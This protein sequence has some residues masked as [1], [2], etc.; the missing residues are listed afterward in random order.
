MQDS[1]NYWLS[2]EKRF[3]NL[4]DPL[5]QHFGI[6][7]FS[8]TK[9]YLDG[10]IFHLCNHVPWMSYYFNHGLYNNEEYANIF[11]LG[12]YMDY[13]TW[14]SIPK[15][16]DVFDIKRTFGMYHG[17]TMVEREKDCINYY[18]FSADRE[19]ESVNLLYLNSQNL[20]KQ[21]VAYFKKNAVDI[22]NCK[23][24]KKLINGKVILPK[25]SHLEHLREQEEV[26]RKTILKSKVLLNVNGDVIQFTPRQHD[27][28]EQL[29]LGRTIRESALTL[30][31]S[32]RTAESYLQDIRVKTRKAPKSELIQAYLDFG[33]KKAL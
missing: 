27:I 20:L 12:R 6:Q 16:V 15:E 25:I 24:E 5:D 33:V 19:R 9:Y 2:V 8:Y 11:A 21:Y 4:C 31:L 18:C 1:F 7:N 14:K 17:F 3:Q 22:I 10:R 23:N 28:L 13:A 29:S 30:G 32:E 26:F